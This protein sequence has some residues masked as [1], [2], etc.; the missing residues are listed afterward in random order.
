MPHGIRRRRDDSLAVEIEELDSRTMRQNSYNYFQHRGSGFGSPLLLSSTFR[1][2]LGRSPASKKRQRTLTEQL[3][4]LCLHNPSS[5]IMREDSKR[6]RCIDSNASRL[7]MEW[8]RPNE[9]NG[10]RIVKLDEIGRKTSSFEYRSETDSDEVMEFTEDATELIVYNDINHG[11]DLCTYLAGRSLDRIYRHSVAVVGHSNGAARE[12]NEIV[13]YKPPR[14]INVPTTQRLPGYFALT[15]QEFKKLSM[16]EKRMWY[17]ENEDIVEDEIEAK[18]HDYK[19]C[20]TSTERSSRLYQQ[21]PRI[22]G[23]TMSVVDKSRVDVDM[24][25]DDGGLQCPHAAGVLTHVEWFMDDQL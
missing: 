8:A 1:S 12:G 25:G 23:E 4:S 20:Q 17:H 18:A 11:K 9:N 2:S 16:A 5:Q 14:S 21:V 7:S 15:P 19:R 24:V 13:I 6:S 10:A 3:E 22:Y